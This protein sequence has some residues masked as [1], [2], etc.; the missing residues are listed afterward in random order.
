MVTILQKA[1][2]KYMGDILEYCGI[3]KNFRLQTVD[4]LFLRIASVE[5]KPTDMRF[6]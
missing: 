5:K 6:T 3:L 4:K 2:L 1:I